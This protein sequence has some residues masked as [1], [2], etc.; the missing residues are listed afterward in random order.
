MEMGEKIYNLRMAK[1]MT[2]EE[3]GNAVGVGKST[4]RK[5]EKGIISNMKRDKIAKLAAALGTTP[6]YL[7]GWD[8]KNIDTARCFSGV[9]SVVKDY[10]DNVGEHTVPGMKLIKKDGSE[11]HFEVSSLIYSITESLMNMPTEKQEMIY[12]MVEGQNKRKKNIIFI[13]NP[14]NSQE[15][16]KMP[17]NVSRPPMPKRNSLNAAHERTDIKVTEEMKQ[18]DDAF[19]DEED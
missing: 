3:L 8:E 5:W 14:S 16:R 13:S 6:A 1:G 12:D 15:Y 11:Y 7:M 10:M 2:L 19:F 18:H 9:D 4:V 17:K